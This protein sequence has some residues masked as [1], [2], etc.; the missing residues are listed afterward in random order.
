MPKG[1]KREGAGRPSGTGRYAESA[2]SIRVPHSLIGP[3]SEMLSEHLRSVAAGL[4]VSEK[5][6]RTKAVS[7][8]VVPPAGSASV[9]GPVDATSMLCALADQKI[10]AAVVVLDP[11]YRGK[12]E[13]GR[14]AYLSETV[15][16]LDA[17][18]RV[19]PNI[20]LWGF[21]ESVARLVDHWPSN[22][23]LEAWLTWFFKNVSSRSKSWRPSQQACLHLRRRDGKLYP[24]RFYSDRHRALAKENKLEF[25]MTPYSV[26]EQPLLSGFIR[27]SEQTGFRMQKPEAVIEPLLRMTTQPSDLVIDPTCGSGTTGAVAIKLGCAAIL[28]DRSGHAL[29]ISRRRLNQPA[30]SG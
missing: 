27:K 6:V 2:R 14:A 4:R 5:Q 12:Q 1:G 18:A 11:M 9:I 15:P 29:R 23:K 13:A 21:P 25:K 24:E 19:A 26:I 17:A 3:V 20:F 30:R 8:I 28:S 16:L 7:P 22:L 10:K